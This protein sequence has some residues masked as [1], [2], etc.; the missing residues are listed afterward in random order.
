MNLIKER[1]LLRKLFNK[2]I[3]NLAIKKFSKIDKSLKLKYDHDSEWFSLVSSEENFIKIEDDIFI[4]IKKI[5]G[6]SMKK[7]FSPL[8][9]KKKQKDSKELS[10][11]IY[12][13]Y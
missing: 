9:K 2:F 7:D 13:M 12:I 6:F 10:S 8:L 5:C 3:G 11:D 1:L 4:Q